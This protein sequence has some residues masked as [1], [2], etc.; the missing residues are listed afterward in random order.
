M[1]SAL[2]IIKHEFSEISIHPNPKVTQG[3]RNG[4]ALKVSNQFK[5][6]P[7]NK[8]QTRWVARLRVELLEP[9]DGNA[10]LYTGAIELVGNFELNKDVNPDDQ[11]KYA[12]VNGGALLYGA[13]REM[14]ATLSSRCIHG[15]VEL[16][17]IDPR[18]FL[19]ADG[20]PEK[21]T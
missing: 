16:P 13:A 10:A 3:Q 18:I 4:T 14:L 15:L 5:A 8:E 7:T 12:C 19:P 17:S 1:L 9:D 2:Q 20:E 21:K 11:I 6:Q